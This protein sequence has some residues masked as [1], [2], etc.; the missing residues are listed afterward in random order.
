MGLK[1]IHQA[2]HAGLY[3]LR[4]IAVVF[5]VEGTYSSARGP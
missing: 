1:H 2:D 3:R 5:G 4:E